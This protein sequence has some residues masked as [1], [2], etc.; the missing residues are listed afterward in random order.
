MTR[1]DPV[2]LQRLRKA[3]SLS[4][5]QLASRRPRLRISQR[6]TNRR[7]RALNEASGL[8]SRSRTIRQ[9]AHALGVDPA[10]LTG[11]SPAP[12][13]SSESSALNSKSQLNVRVGTASPQCPEFGGTALPGGAVADRRTCAVPVCLRRRRK[14]A[15]TSGAGQRGRTCVRKRAKSGA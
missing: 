14:L 8:E 2:V 7:S 5:E 6:S 11:D 1:V 12:D 15:S 9:L 3:K 10:V 4:Q 13:I